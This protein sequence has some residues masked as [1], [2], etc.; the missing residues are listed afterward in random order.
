MREKS[1][2]IRPVE[3][4]LKVDR[5][6]RRRSPGPFYLESKTRSPVRRYVHRRPVPGPG[7]GIG[8]TAG[9]EG[10]H[11]RIVRRQRDPLDARRDRAGT[12][13]RVRRRTVSTQANLDALVM[14]PAD[15]VGGDRRPARTAV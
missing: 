4:D 12:A 10:C 11:G 5:P 15:I 2:E 1:L 7:E 9:P 3:T 13:Q 6:R 14:K 8:P